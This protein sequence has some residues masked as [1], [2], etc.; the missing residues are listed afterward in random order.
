MFVMEVEFIRGN[1]SKVRSF[2]VLFLWLLSSKDQVL[3]LRG[4]EIIRR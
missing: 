4:L 3:R 2:P 1:H